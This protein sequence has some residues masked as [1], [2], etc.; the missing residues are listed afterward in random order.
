MEWVRWADELLKLR[1]CKEYEKG[2]QTFSFS[3]ASLTGCLDRAMGAGGGIDVSGIF[4]A[5]DWR[6][7]VSRKSI[8]SALGDIYL[9]R[10]KEMDTAGRCRKRGVALLT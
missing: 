9:S 5:V 6:N 8:D 10:K 2:K 1:C 7:L 4:A 3:N